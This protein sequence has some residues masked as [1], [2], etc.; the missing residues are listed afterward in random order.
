[1]TGS[2]NAE[3]TFQMLSAKY[4]AGLVMIGLYGLAL[5]IA[6]EFIASAAVRSYDELNTSGARLSLARRVRSIARDAHATT[7]ALTQWRTIDS[8]GGARMADTVY[9]VAGQGTLRPVRIR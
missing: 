1:M 9:V 6:A 5:F 4:I 8:C 3:R 2:Q 7:A